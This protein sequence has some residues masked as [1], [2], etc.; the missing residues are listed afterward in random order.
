MDSKLNPKSGVEMVHQSLK[1]VH[2]FLC[3]LE[4]QTKLGLFTP[5]PEVEIERVPPEEQSLTLKEDAF[6]PDWL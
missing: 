5:Q 1:E 4:E 6:L 2:H 3:V